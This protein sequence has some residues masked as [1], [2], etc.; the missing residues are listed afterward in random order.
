[1][2]QTF[3]GTLVEA[4]EKSDYVVS[5]YYAVCVMS[6]DNT[7]LAGIQ[8]LSNGGLFGKKDPSFFALKLTVR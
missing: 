4:D 6:K 8:S 7:M 1:M 5:D 3:E 2:Y